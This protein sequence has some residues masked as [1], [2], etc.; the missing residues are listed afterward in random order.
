M[1]PV[2]SSDTGSTGTALERGS[3]AH[4]REQPARRLPAAA[5]TRPPAR[6][7]PDTQWCR[8]RPP[9][10]APAPR[11]PIA[12]LETHYPSHVLLCDLIVPT[13]CGGNMEVVLNHE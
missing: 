3:P 4:R 5:A 6:R 10:P 12:S 9:Q 8:S 1:A 13:N 11:P 7:L 2:D